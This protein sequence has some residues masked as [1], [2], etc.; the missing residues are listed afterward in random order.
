MS[1]GYAGRELD[2]LESEV[3]ERMQEFVNHIDTQWAINPGQGMKV[4]DMARITQF[5]AVDVI[6]QLCFGKPLSWLHK[7]QQRHVQLSQNHRDSITY[8]PAFHSHS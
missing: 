2:R 6:T 4:L 1:A 7:Q 3:C 5:L 8:R